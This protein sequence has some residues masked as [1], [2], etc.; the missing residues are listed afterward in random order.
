M[1][2]KL[3]L[4]AEKGGQLWHGWSSLCPGACNVFMLHVALE[5]IQLVAFATCHGLGECAV[6]PAIHI[7]D[8]CALYTGIRTVGLAR[9]S[10]SSPTCQPRRIQYVE[11]ICSK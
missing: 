3:V 6:T 5:R 4:L 8:E 9:V 10:V 2:Q 7:N 1:L 11:D